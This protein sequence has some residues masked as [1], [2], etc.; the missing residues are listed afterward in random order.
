MKPGDIIA[1]KY[2]VERTLGAGGMG[3]VVAARHLA[4]GE[5]VTLKFMRPEILAGADSVA[6]FLREARAAVRLKSVHVARVLY[7]AQLEDGTPYIVMEYLE[8]QDL[9]QLLQQ[10]G[11]VPIDLAVEHVAQACEAISEAHARGIVHGDL[12]PASLFLTRAANG[13]PLLKVLGFGA[14]NAHANA[15]GEALDARADIRALGATLFELLTGHAP[16]ATGTTPSS[17]SKLRKEIPAELSRVILRA[18]AE[19]PDD[20]GPDAASFAR[21]LAPFGPADRSALLEGIREIVVPSSAPATSASPPLPASVRQAS[22][23]VAAPVA[24]QGSRRPAYAA[25]GAL[26]IAVAVV[27]FMAGRAHHQPPLAPEIAKPSFK[28]TQTRPPAATA[29]NTA[30]TSVPGNGTANLLG[31]PASMYRPRP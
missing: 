15:S 4:L 16:V 20:R 1:G 14:S 21:A 2:R 7:V 9:A 6:R 25:V 28:K 22:A 10:Y 12:T 3:V 27:A 26:A 29:T 13:M 17:P 23:T 11:P 24:G 19:S 5:L 31:N 8:G 30:P 18:L